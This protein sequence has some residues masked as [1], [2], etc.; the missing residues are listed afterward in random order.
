MTDATELDEAAT[1]KAAERSLNTGDWWDPR[2]LREALD[3]IADV[4]D[5]TRADAE[6][7]WQVRPAKVLAA[8]DEI[9]RLQAALDEAL[10][11]HLCACGYG[12]VCGQCQRVDRAR[13]EA[14]ERERDEARA[15]VE[16][17]KSPERDTTGLTYGD[18][19]AWRHLIAR[20]E[21]A[22]SALTT[23]RAGLTEALD[24]LVECRSFISVETR[25]YPTVHAINEVVEHL[26]PLATPT[27]TD[28]GDDR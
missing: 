19:A 16:R 10:S 3:R 21:A 23:V 26:R 11:D 17:L 5:D 20:A 22:E 14:A 9:T 28:E 12:V 24:E 18:K 7:I 6:Y 25:H 13:A 2:D 8:L 27:T 15:E 1:R 4:G